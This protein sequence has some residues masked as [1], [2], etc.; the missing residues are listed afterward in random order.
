M[1]LTRLQAV[2]VGAFCIHP[3]CVVSVALSSLRTEPGRDRTVPP[4]QSM[5]LNVN[6]RLLMIDRDRASPNDENGNGIVSNF[7]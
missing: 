1:E 7:F 4:C 2:D 6:G 3:T 5:V